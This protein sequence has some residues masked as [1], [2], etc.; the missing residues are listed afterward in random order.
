VSSA[1]QPIDW[2]SHID[3]LTEVRAVLD[4]CDV[5]KLFSYG[6]PRAGATEDELRTAEAHLGEPLDAQYRAF[7]RTAN[8]WPSF[9]QANDLFGTEELLGG[10]RMQNAR[11]LL[12]FLEREAV[13]GHLVHE[14]DYL[15]IGVSD[16]EIDL[17]LMTRRHTARP[18]N[19]VWYAGYPI[20]RY[21][22]F[23]SFVRYALKLQRHQI[24]YF[25]S[26]SNADTEQRNAPNKK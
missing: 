5:E 20:E 7:L 22:T 4:Q 14:A 21:E 17:F 23:E 13:P 15:P 19:V 6:P 25:R 9:F 1:E 16:T 12:G 2:Q 11:E 3:A 8:G 18:G 26:R 24:E 10:S